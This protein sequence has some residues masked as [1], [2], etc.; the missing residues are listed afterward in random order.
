MFKK[1]SNFREAG[2]AN[3]TNTSDTISRQSIL[4]AGH[5]D[6]NKIFGSNPGPITDQDMNTMTADV[7]EKKYTLG[8]I[9]DNLTK[10]INAPNTMIV[11]G[12]VVPMFDKTNVSSELKACLDK[13][14]DADFSKELSKNDIQDIL[15]A[16]GT[17]A[18]RTK[19]GELNVQMEVGNFLAKA[20][21]EITAQYSQSEGCETLAVTFNKTL[22]AKKAITCNIDKQQ[23]KTSN[24]VTL[25]NDLTVEIG[26]DAV[27]CAACDT[28]SII[29][30]ASLPNATEIIER[31][32]DTC[33]KICPP[34]KIT[35]SNIGK[36]VNVAQF[37][38]QQTNEMK[39]LLTDSLLT[40]TKNIVD[41]EKEGISAATGTKAITGSTTAGSQTIGNNTL[42][43][44]L[45]E[46]VNGTSLRNTAKF[47]FDGYNNGPC[48][49][50]SQSNL[51][52]ATSS[53]F[54]NSVASN[55]T[56]N[57]AFSE[58]M[59]LNSN[60]LSEKITP[61]EFPRIS[62]G[63]SMSQIIIGIIAVVVIGGGGYMS[64]RTY[65]K[66]NDVTTINTV[67]PGCE[68][69]GGFTKALK[70]RLIIYA[71]LFCLFIVFLIIA[72]MKIKEGISAILNPTKWFS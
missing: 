54:F 52:D 31:M 63:M 24:Q 65:S 33:V 69:G 32:N 72:F 2:N 66:C 18:C 11:D 13:Q 62:S 36:V 45:M 68:I 47:K 26:R 37:S 8:A 10:I 14:I 4:P 67:I 60:T 6:K 16:T 55:I 30:V 51:L 19:E 21:G 53:T 41:K 61:R 70:T 15:K 28:K 9:Q 1:Y 22:T 48:V 46:T 58:A 43:D 39:N 49:I 7:L 5:P 25:S 56:K 40:D 35:Q 57:E 17:Q 3:Q 42:S 64:Y 20:K 50:N 12:K 27:C 71:V 29:A 38:K 34:D 59:N 44:A 23:S